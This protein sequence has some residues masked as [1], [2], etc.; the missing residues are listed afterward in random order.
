MINPLKPIT[1]G[2]FAMLTLGALVAPGEAQQEQPK[3]ILVSL[4]NA[5]EPFMAMMRAEAESEAAQLHVSLAFADGKGDSA[6]QAN[7]LENA[8]TGKDKIDGIILAPNDVYALAPTIDLALEKGMPVVTVDRRLYGTSKPVPHV[9]IDNVVGGRVLAQWVVH[10]FPDGA[11]VLHLT[12]QPGSSSGI[13]RAEGV[14]AELREAG[15]KY[16]IVGDVVGNWSRTEAQAATERQLAFLKQ[17]PQVIVAD[18]D[19]MAVG[20]LQGIHLAGLDGADIKVV[21]FDALPFALAKLREGTMA[22]T[23]DQQGGLQMRLALQ[24]LVEQLR[25]GKPMESAKVDPIL[26]TPDKLN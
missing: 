3:S 1:F 4:P 5:S 24:R 20:A 18:N 6:R 22:A 12:G 10:N 16:Q 15:S 2:I 17:P 21:G 14:R 19:D 26:V 7:D 25:T 23:V 9:G 8:V 13:E 11:R